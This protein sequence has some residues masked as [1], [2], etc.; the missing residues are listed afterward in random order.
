MRSTTVLT[1]VIVPEGL[2][3]ETPLLNPGLPPKHPIIPTARFKPPSSFLT[4]TVGSGLNRTYLDIQSSPPDVGYPPRPVPG[5]IAD[6]DIVMDHCDFSN[7][8]VS[9]I[10]MCSAETHGVSVS[11]SGIV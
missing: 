2:D 1:L 7:N 9:H 8:K 4:S 3:L 10:P 11:M 6:L 5:S